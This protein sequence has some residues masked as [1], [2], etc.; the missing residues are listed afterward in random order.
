MMAPTPP[1]EKEGRA[2]GREEG[3]RQCKEH[4]LPLQKHPDG[5]NAKN[6]T[7][8]KKREGRATEPS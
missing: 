4:N 7:F 5:A 1:F 2:V 3:G 6:T 8:E